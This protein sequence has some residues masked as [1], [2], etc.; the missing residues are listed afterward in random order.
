MFAYDYTPDQS[1][2]MVAGLQQSVTQAILGQQG[3]GGDAIV[4]D[5]SEW[6]TALAQYQLQGDTVG[7][8]ILVFTRGGQLQDQ[9]QLGTPASFFSDE[10]NLLEVSVDS[11]GGGGGTPE[12]GTPTPDEGDGGS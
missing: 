6:N 7:E 4:S 1:L 3:G 10:F 12:E 9:V 11:G 5:P 2:Q 8:Y